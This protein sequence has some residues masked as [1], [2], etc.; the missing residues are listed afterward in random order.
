MFTT[1]S[2]A[3]DNGTYLVFRSTRPDAVRRT[4]TSFL[5]RF[6]LRRNAPLPTD[7][8]AQSPLLQ[9]LSARELA[10]ARQ[11]FTQMDIPAGRTVMTEGEV[12]HVFALLLSGHLEIRRGGEAI[13]EI[14]DGDQFGEVALLRDVTH[15]D[16]RRNATVVSLTPATLAVCSE[17]ELE[18]LTR[19]SDD[20]RT[21]LE[22]IALSRV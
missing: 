10:D 22:A 7:R 14:D 20:F 18:Q 11:R 12:G 13:D 3:R 2:S 4:Q 17:R 5:D 19:L 15:S 8:V 1:K 9:N 6:R 21:Q 16:G